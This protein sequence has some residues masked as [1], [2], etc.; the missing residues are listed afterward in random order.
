MKRSALYFFLIL[1]LGLTIVV[2]TSSCVHYTITT[3]E[4]NPADIAFKKKVVKAL[5]WGKINVP[6]RLVDSCGDAGLDEVKIS[7]NF[8]YTLL[9][10]VTLGI[11]H[12]V[13]VEWKCHKA[14]SQIGFKPTP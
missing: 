13:K 10:L 2:G 3:T 9:H 8:G 7:S 12:K 6:Q 1:C 14:C 4:N 5:W 11:V